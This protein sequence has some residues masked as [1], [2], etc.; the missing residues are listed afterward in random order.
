LRV[1]AIVSV[2]SAFVAFALPSARRGVQV[3]VGSG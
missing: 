1:F 3:S 2:V